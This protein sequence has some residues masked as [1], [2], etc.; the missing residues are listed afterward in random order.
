M[1]DRLRQE[2]Q[3][4]RKQV[5]RLMAVDGIFRMNAYTSYRIAK[6]PELE[7]GMMALAHERVADAVC[8]QFTGYSDDVQE[9]IFLAREEFY[10]GCDTVFCRYTATDEEGTCVVEWWPAVQI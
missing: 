1:I 7:E 5:E 3:E 8:E 6:R 2:N 10:P 4:L 9:G